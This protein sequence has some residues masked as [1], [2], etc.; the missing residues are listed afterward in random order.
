MFAAAKERSR[1]SETLRGEELMG[2]QPEGGA[3]LAKE[4]V[5]REASGASCVGDAGGFVHSGEEKIAAAEEAA[6][7]LLARRCTYGGKT[8][9]CLFRARKFAD[10]GPRDLKK[11]FFGCGA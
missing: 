10:E 3:E 8:R 9:G 11:C 7:K 1:A 6:K 5:A 2:C 4:V